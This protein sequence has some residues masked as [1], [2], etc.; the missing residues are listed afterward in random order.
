MNPA[1]KLCQ[2]LV[3]SHTCTIVCSSAKLIKD[4]TIFYCCPN[5][6]LIVAIPSSSSYLLPSER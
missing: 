1:V 4:I 6:V 5:L 2:A 3:A